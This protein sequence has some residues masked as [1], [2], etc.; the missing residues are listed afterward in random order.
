MKKGFTLI[1]VLLAVAILSLSVVALLTNVTNCLRVIRRAQEY[2]AV[3]WTLAMGEAD[4]PPAAPEK[5]EDLEVEPEEYENGLTY[6]REVEEDDDKDELY[7]VKEK[8][9]WSWHGIEQAEEVVRYVMI[10][11]KTES[12]GGPVTPGPA[13]I[14]PRVPTAPRSPAA[15]T[16]RPYTLPRAP[17]LPRVPSAPPLPGGAIQ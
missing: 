11:D 17:T 3:Q 14:V 1:E 6:A 16:P 4:H 8:V 13:P 9:T 2:Q 7:V 10:Q 12:G 15:P 5:P